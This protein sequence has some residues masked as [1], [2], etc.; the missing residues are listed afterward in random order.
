MK[1][2]PLTKHDK[3]NKTTLKRFD[4]DVMSKNYDV[5]VIFR[6]FGQFGAIQRVDSGYRVCNNYVF[7]NS[8]RF[9]VP[10]LK[11]ELKKL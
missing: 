5:I 4:V 6:N 9:V 7:S 3:R 11:T 1:H 10:K 2:G 8:N